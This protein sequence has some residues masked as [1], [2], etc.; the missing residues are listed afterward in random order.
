MERGTIIEGLRALEGALR[1]RGVSALYLFGSAA[2]GEAGADSDI[3]LFFEHA[4]DARL[5][6]LDVLSIR[7]FL[8]DTLGRDIDVMTRK[9]LHPLLRA[10]IEAEAIEVF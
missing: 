6:L 4:S 3:D 9:S 5:S 8:K 10:D 2:R 7:D 1:A